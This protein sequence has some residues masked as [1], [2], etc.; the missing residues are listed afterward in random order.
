MLFGMGTVFIFLTLLVVCVTFM[1]RI[2]SRFFPEEEILVEVK[3]K[4][5]PGPID[6]IVLTVIQEAIYQHRARVDP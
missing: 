1:S 6:P 3:L 5:S 4:T 2:I